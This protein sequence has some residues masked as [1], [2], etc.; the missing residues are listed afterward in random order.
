MAGQFCVCCGNFSLRGSWNKS[1][2]V[3][4]TTYVACDWHSDAAMKD[5][6]NA[7]AGGTAN[8]ISPSAPV[9]S[10]KNHKLKE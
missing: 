4:G 8:S 9:P 7:V 6:A 1:V 3:S 10:S 2:F 5:A